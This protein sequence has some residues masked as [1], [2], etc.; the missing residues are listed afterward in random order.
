MKITYQEAERIADAVN[1]HSALT[2]IV[3]QRL[4]AALDNCGRF[5]PKRAG[6]WHKSDRLLQRIRSHEFDIPLNMIGDAAIRIFREESEK[7]FKTALLEHLNVPPDH[8]KADRLFAIAW[9]EGHAAGHEDVMNYA[10]EF[11]ELLVLEGTN[12]GEERDEDG[13]EER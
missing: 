11:V 10:E 13:K 2:D 12:D 8:P 7:K 4:Q 3:F 1:P 5:T 9:E 6:G